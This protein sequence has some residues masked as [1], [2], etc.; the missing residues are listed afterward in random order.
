ML[1]VQKDILFQAFK[2][3]SHLEMGKFPDDTKL[4]RTIVEHTPIALHPDVKIIYFY[5]KSFMAN[6]P[7]CTI[8]L[9]HPLWI[10]I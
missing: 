7:T 4:L 9:P 10:I 1:F 3:L 6:W 5:R 2:E 8:L